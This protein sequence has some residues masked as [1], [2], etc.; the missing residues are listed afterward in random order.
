[1]YSLLYKKRFN[2]DKPKDLQEKSNYDKYMENIIKNKMNYK[3]ALI[4]QKYLKNTS[5]KI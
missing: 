3:C 5:R 2:N 4:L 1:M